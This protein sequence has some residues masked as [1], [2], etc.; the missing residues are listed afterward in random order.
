[1]VGDRLM[2][3]DIVQ[4]VFLKFFE[5]MELIRNKNSV[6]FWIFKTA[7]NE[8]YTYYRSKKVKVDQFS[9]ADIEDIEV[10]ANSDLTDEF[11]LKEIS[12]II[13]KELDEMA[14][15]QREVFVLKEYAGMSYK[16][17]SQLMGIDE[18]LVKSR[19]YNTRQRLINRISKVLK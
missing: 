19:L 16:E 11:E 8:I 4:N 17:I 10:A 5:N 7:R 6:N 14:F 9:V 1:M 2:C 15:E 12:E 13:K 3:E 18:N